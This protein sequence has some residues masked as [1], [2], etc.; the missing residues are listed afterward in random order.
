MDGSTNPKRGDLV[1]FVKGR[2]R[3][4]VRDIRV[5]KRQEATFVR[6]RL[7]DI[8]RVDTEDSKNKGTAKFIAA[9]EKEEMYEINLV[10]VVSCD[11]KMLK[12][13]EAVEGVLYE[14][15]IFGI[16]RTC[17]LYL[18]SKLGTQHKERPKL[19]LTV[20]K[21]RGGKIMAQ[22]MMAKGPD[23]TNGF[24]AGWT[25]RQSQYSSSEAEAK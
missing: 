23:G 9:T 19:N 20:K 6:G 21:D 3:N 2:K 15:K 12:E 11:A 17:D 25:T 10:E 14:G 13:K 18:T 1:S 16:C 4:T 5:E 7:E 22:S 8:K 24:K